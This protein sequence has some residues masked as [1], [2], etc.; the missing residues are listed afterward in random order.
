MCVHMKK[1]WLRG[2]MNLNKNEIPEVKKKNGVIEE[3]TM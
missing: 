2:F 3:T 1:I